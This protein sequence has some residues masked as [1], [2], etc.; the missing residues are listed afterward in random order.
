MDHP[1]TSTNYLPKGLNVVLLGSMFLAQILSETVFHNARFFRNLDGGH[2]GFAFHQNQILL[3]P[4]D[5][6]VARY[7]PYDCKLLGSAIRPRGDSK[8]K[9]NSR[10]SKLFG[11]SQFRLRLSFIPIV[12]FSCAILVILER[13]Y[14]DRFPLKIEDYL[15]NSHWLIESR[16]LGLFL[17][18]YI[19]YVHCDVLFGY[20]VSPILLPRRVCSV[21][22]Q[23]GERFPV[24]GGHI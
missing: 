15:V 10:N 24:A 16:P 21:F 3:W 20:A 14:F 11:L 13:Y 6:A 18:T 8:Q 2:T 4:L 12:A 22:H 7:W 17:R 1:Q 5:F 9:S 19:S 23:C